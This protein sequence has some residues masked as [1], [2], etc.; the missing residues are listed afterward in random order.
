MNRSEHRVHLEAELSKMIGRR[1]WSIVAGPGTGSVVSLGLGDKVRRTKPLTNSHLSYDQRMFESEFEI[2]I[3]S[4]WRLDGPS[5]VIC[6]GWDDNRP[7][8]PMLTGLRRLE[9]KELLDSHVSDPGLDL[10]LC[11]ED[12][13]RLR[14]F[15]DQINE[16]D[17][18]DNYS[19]VTPEFES[20]VGTRS[21]LQRLRR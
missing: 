20:I 15:C 18:G 17:Q 6:G 12:D 1:C 2:F 14:V 7:E 19:V 5:Q 13:L 3:E 4:F 8:G 11:F 16:A 9:G 10:V 21:L